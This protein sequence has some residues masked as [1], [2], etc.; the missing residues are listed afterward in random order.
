MCSFSLS[1]P[2]ILLSLFHIWVSR[3]G[4]FYF[5]IVALPLSNGCGNDNCI[6]TVAVTI[7]LGLIEYSHVT[8]TVQNVIIQLH[9]PLKIILSIHNYPH[10]F[11]ST[12]KPCDFEF[13]FFLFRSDT[14]ATEN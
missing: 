12:N 5:E 10:I 9:A 4:D 6:S 14:A 3:F 1:H 13:N 8:R 2:T 11:F 7:K